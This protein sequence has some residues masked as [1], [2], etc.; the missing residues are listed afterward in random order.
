MLVTVFVDGQKLLLNPFMTTL[1]A[2]V[3]IAIA[4]S[5]KAPDG[6]HL[7]FLLKGEELQ[8]QVDKQPVDLN[9]GRAKRIVGNLLRGLLVSLHGTE[10]GTEFRFVCETETQ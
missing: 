4:R 5:L 7:E 9:L 8:L 1:S 3:L 2:N 6:R 10:S